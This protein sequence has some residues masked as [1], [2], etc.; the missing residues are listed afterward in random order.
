MENLRPL[1]LDEAVGQ[2][3]AKQMLSVIIK[4]H[5][6][7]KQVSPHMIFL[8]PTGVGKTTLANIVA[9]ELGVKFYSVMGSRID[10]WDNLLVRIK[11]LKEGDILF[12]DEIHKLSESIQLELYGIMEDF[13]YDG[14]RWENGLK[15]MCK[16][17]I[18]KFTLIGATTD[19]GDLSLPLMGRFKVKIYLSYYTQSELV[20]MISKAAK[21]IYGL[22]GIPDDVVNKIASLSKRNARDAI[23]LL[24][25]LM[26]VAW[27]DIGNSVSG[28]QLTVF[29]LS[30]SLFVQG[31]D[32]IIGLDRTSRKYLQILLSEGVALGLISLVALVNEQPETIKTMIEPYLMNEIDLPV[33]G[34]IMRGPFVKMTKKGRI[35]I[36]TAAKYLELCLELQ[37]QGWFV[38]E[39]LL[40]SKEDY[41]IIN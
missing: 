27:G 23:N 41:V 38:G 19:T 30:K 18:P 32:P 33:D 1:K 20:D 35:A 39:K 17:S 7:T 14:I 25:N 16:K 28:R 24:D 31:I 40:V 37:K 5:K 22:E 9:N 34:H 21:R 8:G 4:S 26:R 6:E 13:M 36:K 12:I 15:K 2:E 3:T 10:S 11:E 29:L